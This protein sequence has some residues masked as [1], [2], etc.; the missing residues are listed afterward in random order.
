MAEHTVS[1]TIKGKEELEDD[2]KVTFESPFFKSKFPA[3]IYVQP[4]DATR[5]K[6]GQAYNLRLEQGKLSEGKDGSQPWHYRWKFLGIATGPSDPAK[7][8]VPSAGT[9][10][11]QGVQERPHEAPAPDARD[12][13]IQRQVALKAAVEWG[14][15]RLRGGEKVRT[16]HVIQIADWFARWMQDGT[17]PREPKEP[18]EPKLVTA[19]KAM[20]AVETQEQEDGWESVGAAA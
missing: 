19:A 6:T 10:G 9:M 11:Q 17:M 2:F 13:S 4:E 14:L 18:K 8:P 5:I 1:G 15:E 20:G 16:Y 3:I 12:R 7:A